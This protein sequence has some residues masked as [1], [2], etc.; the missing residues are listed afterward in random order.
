MST[1]A[2][3]SSYSSSSTENSSGSS[4][5]PSQTLDQA[6]FLQL[7][8]TQMSN[9]DPMNPQSDAEFIAQMAQFSSLEQS[10]AMMQDMASLRA[11]NL[12]GSTVTVTD[13]NNADGYTTG[14]VEGVFMNGN[15]PELL[16]N[17]ERYELST[18]QNIAS[19]PT[20]TESSETASN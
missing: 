12:L 10:K 18:I 7:L 9:Q 15:T 13:E 8:T 19:T 5:V 16:I 17:G 20:T 14:V 3:V 2:S 11:S 4:R 1:I 6:D